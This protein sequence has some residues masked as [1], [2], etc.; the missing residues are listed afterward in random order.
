MRF[1]TSSLPHKACDAGCGNQQ[2]WPRLALSK[3]SIIV[4]IKTRPSEKKFQTAFCI[5]PLCSIFGAVPKRLPHGGR[6]GLRLFARRHGAGLVGEAA[7]C[8]RQRK[9][10]RHVDR[11]A[12]ARH[13]GVEQRGILAP[14]HNVRG[15]R[16]QAAAVVAAPRGVGPALAQY[17]QGI[18]VHHAQ[19]GADGRGPGHQRAAAGIE[20]AAAGD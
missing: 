19:A 7:G 9:G 1:C 3:Q 15:L 17:A 14:F 6:A 5:M 2:A 18:F 20:Q 4:H 10:T 13:G 11:V 12:R 16:G 8:H